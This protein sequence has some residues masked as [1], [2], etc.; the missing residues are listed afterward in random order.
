M[1]IDTR[2]LGLFSGVSGMIC[3]AGYTWVELVLVIVVVAILAVVAVPILRGRIDMAKWSEGK[4]MAGTI[5]TALHTYVAGNAIAGSWDEIGLSARELGFAAGDLSGSYF[6]ESNF[7]WEL[8][9][10]GT[11]ETFLI[12]ITRPLELDGPAE[13]TLDHEGNWTP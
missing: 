2:V 13:V 4:A 11:R 3:R 6:S 9:C 12:T 1:T 5:A 8:S 10:D 7:K